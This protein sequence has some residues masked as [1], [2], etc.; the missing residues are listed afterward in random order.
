MQRVMVPVAVLMVR[1]LAPWV[2]RRAV[3][4]VVTA[5]VMVRV[6]QVMPWLMVPLV[7]CTVKML[8]VL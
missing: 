1:V 6:F 8:R 4:R 7:M 2:M 3:L 5:M